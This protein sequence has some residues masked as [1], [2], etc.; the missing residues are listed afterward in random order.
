MA[1]KTAVEWLKQQ[2]L[3]RDGTL[4]SGVFQE[5][6]EMEKEQI[7]QAAYDNMCAITDDPRGDAE[8]YYKEKYEK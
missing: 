5:A 2:Y 3:E 6:K 4:P 8:D 1:K 7:I